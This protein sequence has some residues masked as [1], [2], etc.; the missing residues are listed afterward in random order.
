VKDDPV[1]I[2]RRTMDIYFVSALLV[3][4][5]LLG[6]RIYLRSPHSPN[7]RLYGAF[8]AVLSVWAV[9]NFLE[10]EP[11][12]IG[13]GNLAFF[14][15]VD[16]AFAPV[17]LYLWLRF[18]SV[19]TRNQLETDAH[20]R[21]RAVLLI[22]IAAAALSPFWGDALIHNIA[23]ANSVI[24]FGNG[25]LWGCYA[26]LVL[27]LQ[28]WALIILFLGSR[29]ARRERNDLL[30]RQIGLIL[31]GS[32]ISMMILVVIN[33]SQ[34]LIPIGL[35]V[36]RLGLYGMVFMVVF[37]AYAILKHGLFDIRIAI[38]RGVIYIAL[39]ALIVGL[40]L[41]VISVLGGFLH[42]ATQLTA[43]A[44]GVLTAVIGIITVPRIERYFRRVTD[45]IF[46]KDTYD[47]ASAVR[48][49]SEVLNRSV[50]REEIVAKTTAK[51]KDIF[52]VSDIDFI[53]L[54]R[55][56]SEH[57]KSQHPV[58]L[59]DP[60]KMMEALNALS[61]IVIHSQTPDASGLDEEVKKGV[62]EIRQL[63]KERNV[64]I[65]APIMLD[66]RVLGI[67]NLGR[68]LSGDSYTKEDLQ[69]LETFSCQAAVALEKAE[70]YEQVKN[71]AL[72]LEK[73]VKERTAELQQLQEGQ[74]RMMVDVSHALQ[75]PLTVVKG[76]L[77]VLKKQLPKNKNL[78]IF[79]K[80]IDNVS[81][82]TYKLLALAK[83]ETSREDFRKQSVD[84]SRLLHEM[85]EYFGV[86]AEDRGV[87]VESDI[88]PDIAVLGDR[89]MLEEMVTNLLSNSVKYM[90]GGDKRVSI[91]LA[92]TGGTARLSIHDTGVGI[93]KEDLPYIFD[94]FY[95]AKNGPQHGAKG[96]G[97]G[98]AIC[99]RIA[100]KHD[101]S[102]E[103]ESE[104]GKGTTFT[105][106]L[107]IANK[108]PAHVESGQH[109]A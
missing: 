90:A 101:G 14:L 88:K 93:A 48:E 105:L 106:S 19:F 40:Y 99:K 15:R 60:K 10:N 5:V 103:V 2:S 9:A 16:F 64:E 26:L 72:E 28:V 43:L 54:K 98:L 45:K 74:K 34:A 68:K 69:L 100:E 55:S 3:V 33:L 4:N 29:R 76:E 92:K 86:I 44:S 58:S 79:E 37:T 85:I 96:T 32:A 57:F 78:Q 52:K 38:Q 46:F 24:Q 73:R 89:N 63:A 21:L 30:R 36:S 47:Y 25:P 35:E 82:M 11:G 1:S 39:L 65:T 104:P 50:E 75:T 67:L 7:N 84:F 83:L 80:S 17:F 27:I 61:G 23:F 71:D 22:A 31:C 8:V 12:L 87:S 97:L 77:E 6:L 108:E 66:N 49:L 62:A 94:R 56:Y 107:P 18:S 20:R 91:R 13:E 42:Q 41:G 95:R 70:L 109:A 81:A 51:L 59:V 102:I 53:L